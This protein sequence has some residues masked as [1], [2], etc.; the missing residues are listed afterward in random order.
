[1]FSPPT[2]TGA[3]A[4]LTEVRYWKYQGPS[5]PRLQP[6]MS[7]AFHVWMQRTCTPGR[8]QFSAFQQGELRVFLTDVYKYI[9][10]F[11]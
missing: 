4:L 11:A 5:S 3:P 9:L 2:E 8:P 7:R 10:L 6:K 1:M